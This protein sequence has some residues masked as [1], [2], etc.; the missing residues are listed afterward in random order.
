MS[1]AVKLLLFNIYHMMLHTL[2]HQHAYQL[3][4]TFKSI[5]QVFFQHWNVSL[6]HHYD[7]VL[8]A[9]SLLILL[10]KHIL[11]YYEIKGLQSWIFRDSLYQPWSYSWTLPFTFSL[12]KHCCFIRYK[13]NLKEIDSVFLELFCEW[14]VLSSSHVKWVVCNQ[15][16]QQ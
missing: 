11:I 16:F 15:Q 3:S 6:R 14:Q 7:E 8:K 5:A 4:N 13:S 2:S 1:N 9:L 12:Q 10:L